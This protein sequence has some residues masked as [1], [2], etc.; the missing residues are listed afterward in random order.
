MLRGII[1]KYT[2][3][4]GKVYIGQTTEER[5]R[6]R[7]FLNL[8]K[9][10]G[11]E[12]IDAARQKYK[13]E[14]F[15]YEI[16]F[17]GTFVSK[18]EATLKLDE[19]EEYYITLF[20][21]YRNGYNMTFGGYTTRGFTFT[22]EQKQEMSRA[23]MG[24]KTRPKTK[25]EKAE[26]SALMKEKW[27][28][29]EY[30]KLQE[31][32]KKSEEHKRKV[33][34]SLSGEK[35]GMFG[36]KHSQAARTKMSVSRSGDKNIWY[37]KRKSEEYREHIRQGAI[38]YYE[39]HTVSEI[40]KKK[41]AAS[42]SVAVCQ[43]TLGGEFIQKFDSA[44]KAGKEIGIDGSCIIK[45][46]K[47]KRKSAGGYAWK[48]ASKPTYDAITEDGID[49]ETWIGIAEAIKI[50]RLDRNVIYYHIKKHGVPILRNGRRIKIHKPSLLAIVKVEDSP[51][52][53]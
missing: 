27:A 2:S 9:S 34:E 44:T 49:G 17:E 38:A 5:R 26:H 45:C 32:I 30:R 12:K 50:T 31:E 10:Y 51:F 15:K 52:P 25:E 18:E 28:T 6:R 4:N 11:G 41:I 36:K 16:L 7:T 40:T 23:R 24:R 35:N 33:S 29:E 3:P 8:N 20:D 19:M 42:I 53:E 47:G 21:T 22:D 48:Y 39:N 46:C 37:G 13:P 14:N 1:Y 43:Y